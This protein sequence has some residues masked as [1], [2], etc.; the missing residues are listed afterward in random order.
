MI[1]RLGL[2]ADAGIGRPGTGR[3]WILALAI[4]ACQYLVSSYAL[5][6]DPGFIFSGSAEAAAV[7]L[8]G[9]AAG[10]LEEFAFRGLVLFAIV[11]RW[12]RSPG[13]LATSVLLSSLMFA[14]SHVL[15]LAVGQP[16]ALVGML[17]LDT[18]LAG[19]YY[20]AF[21]IRARSIWPAVAIHVLLNAFVGARA[22]DVP[23]F[24]ET[25]SAWIPIV[26]SQI[27]LAAIALWMLRKGRGESP[28]VGAA[29]L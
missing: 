11:A 23:G 28:A 2:W 25:V 22:A 18:F 9:S 16:A 24:K 3:V 12:G 14:A 7:A 10:I 4:T 26:L 6:G 8:N 1:R 21:V 5:F 20:A 29:G 27:P 15:R 17:V 19:I 13:A